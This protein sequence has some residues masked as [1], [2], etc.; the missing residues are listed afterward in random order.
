MSE[1]T[2]KSKSGPSM[3]ESLEDRRLFS[4]SALL[5]AG[6]APA[7]AS[8]GGGQGKVA[9]QDIHFTAKVSKPSPSLNIRMEDVL[10]SSYSVSGSN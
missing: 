1:Q 8:G 9:Y 7:A 2:S 3:V 5:D 6:P 10:I 4:A